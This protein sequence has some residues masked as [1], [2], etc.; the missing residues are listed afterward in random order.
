MNTHANPLVRYLKVKFDTSL[1][2]IPWPH[3]DDLKKFDT[4]K[5]KK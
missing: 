3:S 2:H 5:S 1:R 4:Y